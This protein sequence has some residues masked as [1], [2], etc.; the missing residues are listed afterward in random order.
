MG[1]QAR[2]LGRQGPSLSATGTEQ[3]LL[4]VDHPSS[5]GSGCCP[6]LASG[7]LHSALAAARNRASQG[8][9]LSSKA[10]RSW[11]G[12]GWGRGRDD[13]G[14]EQIQTATQGGASLCLH[15][16]QLDVTPH[17]QVVDGG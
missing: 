4:P 7:P 8:R 15:V 13:V 10:P 12:W 1:L 6:V 17:L 2:S 16:G 5:A 3:A 11:A 14:G 9:G